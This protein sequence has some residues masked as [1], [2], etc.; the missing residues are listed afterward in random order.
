MLRARHRRARALVDRR[1]PHRRHQP[2][3][4]LAADSMT[5]ALK[6]AC[7]LA[8]AIPGHFQELGIDRP[9]Q[10]QILHGLVNRPMVEPGPAD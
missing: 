8:R 2:P 7:H 4:A 3:D 1:Q 9:H 10:R 5:L 6:M